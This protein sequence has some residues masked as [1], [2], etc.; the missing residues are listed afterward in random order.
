MRLKDVE[1]YAGLEPDTALFLINRSQLSIE[2]HKFL[3]MHVVTPVIQDERFT[4]ERKLY[5]IYDTLVFTTME[6]A[7]EGLIEVAVQRVERIKKQYKHYLK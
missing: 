2:P 4:H 3:R 6:E 1:D 7:V 5:E